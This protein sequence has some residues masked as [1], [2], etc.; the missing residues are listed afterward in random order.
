MHKSDVQLLGKWI[1]EL[2]LQYC[3][4]QKSHSG[5]KLF[6]KIAGVDDAA[7]PG[8][9]R[10]VQEAEPALA[11]I[12]TPVIR[13][14]SKVE[15][16]E[17]YQCKSHETSTW[18]RNNTAAGNALMIFMTENSSEAQSLENIFTID[19]ARLMSGEGLQI[20]YKMLSED[21]QIYG[22]ELE[23]LTS[24]F[25][26]YNK[27][28]EPQL[29]NVLS[30]LAA[31]LCNPQR[32]MVDNVNQNLHEL[33]L[34]CDRS[35][36][37]TQKE[38]LQR[39]K[40]NYQ[41]SRLEKEGKTSRKEDFIENVYEFLAREDANQ[42]AHEIWE[43]VKP[44]EF[45]EHAV[46]FIYNQSTDFLKYEFDF[47]AEVLLFKARKPKINEKMK[48]FVDQLNGE[49]GQEQKQL[50]TQ[51]LEAIEEGNNP[52]AI[53]SFI[54][55]FTEDLHG[56]PLRKELDRMVSRQRQLQEYTELTDALLHESFR[57]LEENNEDSDIA[58]ARFELRLVNTKVSER[59]Y[60]VLSFHLLQLQQITRRIS[61]D[62]TSL[63][64]SSEKDKEGD[65]SFELIMYLGQTEVTKKKFKLLKVG[66]G[67][68]SAMLE[69]LEDNGKL[70]YVREY[71]GSDV[72]LIDVSAEVEQRVSGYIATGDS[73]VKEAFGHFETFMTMY[74][75]MVQGALREGLGSVNYEHLERELELILR[76]VHE[77]TLVSKHIYQ[78]I[79][80]LGAVDRF[81]CKHDEAGTVQT[82]SLTLLNPI[83][84]LSYAKRLNRIDSE[85][86]S[87]T[88]QLRE[89]NAQVGEIDD[90]IQCIR[91]ETA[92]LS[93]YYFAV[94]GTNDHY[95]IEQQE[96]MGEGTFAI[97]GKSSGEEQL[98]DTFADEFL[99]TVKTY[100]EVYPYAKDCLDFVF[101]Y[102]PHAEYVVKAIDCVFKHAGVRKI[103]ATIHSDTRGAVIHE[104]LNGW[105]SQ[106]ELYSEKLNSFPRVEIQ[107]IA[108]QDINL[109]MKSVSAALQDADIGVLVNYF[110][111][112]SGIQY[113]LEKVHVKDTDQWFE[114][115]YKEPIKKDDA[116]KKISFISE[117]LPKVLQYFYQMQY[118]LQTNQL[119][120][121]QEHFL[122]RN[123]ISIHKTEDASLINF[124][125][126]QFNWSLFIDRYLDKSLLRQVS[127]EAQ[128]I[129]YK[130]KAGKN[131]DFRTILSSSNYIR[132]L[133]NE[134][135]DHAYYDRLYQK[136][137][138][139]LKNDNINRSILVQAVESVKEI[140]GG[141]VLR[142]IGPGKF[143]HELMAMYLST[144]ARER[145]D[146]ALTLWSVC[147]ELPWFHGSQRRPD[148][149]GTTI[150]RDG[151]RIRIQFELIE[152]KF[153]SH[154][155][156]EQE[157]YDAIKQV[158]AG[159]ELY[160][161]RFMFQQ[162]RASAELWRKEL[163]YYLLEYGMYS[164]EHSALLKD[165]QSIPIDHIDVLLSGAI[166]TFVYTSNLM[167]LSVMD[168]QDNGYQTEVLYNEFTNHIYNRSY[169][170][171]ALGAIPEGVSPEYAEMEELDT[172]VSDKLNSGIVEPM[173]VELLEEAEAM[174]NMEPIIHAE[175]LFPLT[176]ISA[177][178]LV[179]ATYEQEAKA[180]A[181][182]KAT[183]SSTFPEQIALLA[184]PHQQDNE[185]EDMQPLVESYHKKLRFNFNQLGI[186]V[187][188][189]DTIIGVSVIRIILE[190]PGD[191]PYSSIENRSKDIQLW[192]QSSLPLIAIRN[193]RIN[194][195][196]NRDKPEVVYF[197]TFMQRVRE[198]VATDQMKGK[199]LAPLGVG[200]LNEII[201]MDFSSPDTPHL[202]IGGRTGS[203]KS[204]TINSIILAMMC[205]YEPADVQF[206]FI[207]PKKVE[208]LTYDNRRHTKQVITEIE[209]A[210]QAL[211]QL[212]EEMEQRYRL[213]A[214]ESVTSIDQYIEVTSSQMPRLVVV[215]DE[216]AD[217]M[218][219]EKSL[220]GRVENAIL[221]LGAKAR[222]AGIHL[223]I[224]T[225]SPKADIVP[226]N[227]R[228]NLPARLALKATDH[229]AS[230]VILD[231]EGAEKLGGKGDF[232]TRLDM[233][234]VQRGKSPFLT[235]NVK[236]ALLQFFS[237]DENR[238]KG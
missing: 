38:G 235:L 77:S 58:N 44:H 69:Y 105:L 102:C 40:K 42:Y 63:Q 202:L 106:E 231:E 114:T 230:K 228:N 33:S 65:V 149:V 225:Q 206:I 170:L 165:V 139:L 119:M 218:I 39:L 238:M 191:K 26:M 9:L 141:V 216:F 136:F 52:D 29:R 198:Q 128:I 48:D 217:F 36:R 150:T 126:K 96:R 21:Y 6:I 227:I 3:S 71:Y 177:Q 188:I 4:E 55:E 117:R 1:V 137:V 87:W 49:L 138:V 103:K 45:R 229:H 18:L 82:R 54:D 57:L 72:R 199:L 189:I 172:F 155:I 127:S 108:E 24:F 35:L 197:E 154:G 156:F 174:L 224:C 143:A 113:K 125:H 167:E 213:F 208:F 179:A 98:V 47:V 68:L 182:L 59:L 140:S 92:H 90:Y 111:Q 115:V 234:D 223:L 85:L 210:V 133:A 233:P 8:V 123:V 185:R 158:R 23:V 122:L 226:T 89:G 160:R 46:A 152:L 161:S 78:Y 192:L 204:V 142:A 16:F 32:S 236:R 97:N 83:R 84:L 196:I 118:V 91:E 43:G 100:L 74:T 104:Y 193:G 135:V 166:D 132:K 215:F 237:L 37:F 134:T 94:E 203:G 80:F 22:Q 129:K 20:L 131:K 67:Q 99:S 121:A 64:A 164:V 145:Q 73:G 62:S 219:Q 181:E 144:Q 107:V 5:D 79:S 159:L 175:M 201:M 12:Y 221:R 14:L 176:D 183:L 112:A 148:L 220:S 171:R 190:I 75:S 151:E 194:I 27:I 187:K 81:S 212:V 30:F 109:I 76:C 120:D 19:E 51:T 28:V 31:V 10:V 153:I 50:L 66:V 15:G 184:E 207:D 146:G 214:N 130:S 60:R 157:R 124:M 101:L 7:W 2:V 116:V 17:S 186:H 61:F 110:G 168:S 147:D 162:N 209:E 200:Q 56:T 178:Q 70:P 53:Q 34:F 211:E 11:A 205:M 163:I 25:G 195:D 222:A 86:E 88:T 95:L 173:E 180:V 13:T 232:L 41:L 169:I 93:P